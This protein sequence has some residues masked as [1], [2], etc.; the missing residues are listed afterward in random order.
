MQMGEENEL[1]RY[2]WILRRWLWLML[3]TTFLAAGAA[4]VF[5]LRTTPVY[6]ATAT[7]L[8]KQAPSTAAS[9]YTAILTSERL[10]RTYAQMIPSTVV[11]ENVVTRLGLTESAAE[12]AE[13]VR[14]EAVRDTLL[15]RL[16]VEDTEPLRAA[17]LANAIAEV[18][19][20]QNRELQEQRYAS[21]L[22]SLQSQ[23]DESASLIE[24]TRAQIEAL[25]E[26]QTAEDRTELARLETILAGYRNTY[27]ALLQSYEQTRLSAAQGSD[28]V[29]MFEPA[30][31]PTVPVRPRTAT[32][33]ALA[34][35]IGL[36]FG[37]GI[38]LLVEYLD[39]TFKSPDDVRRSLDMST[40][41]LIM[42][43]NGVENDL[44]VASDPSSP[45][46][47]AFRVLRT[48]L[49]FSNVD[50]P[51][52]KLL[53]T[54]PGPVE[55]KSVVTANLAAVI[56]QAGLRVVVDADLRR[57]RQHHIFGIRP[58]GGLSRA[59]LEGN[60]DSQVQSGR[61]AGLALLPAGG[62]PANP[63]EVLASQRMVRL[64]E[65]LADQVDVV[66]LDSPPVL[67][68]T[69]ATVLAR[70][71]DGVVL[72]LQA[73]RT[74]RVA[75]QQAVER[76]QQVGATLL[77]TVLNGI[78]PRG[79]GHYY[80]YESYYGKYYETKEARRKRHKQKRR[81]SLAASPAEDGGERG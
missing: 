70:L 53:V 27:S 42:R 30:E 49:W 46:A 51:P 54:S 3:L 45:V 61:L 77:G 1:L 59:L 8:V 43:F 44:I 10:I 74:R 63:A 67:P 52:R 62:L 4:L 33:T 5:S 18:F 68:V 73:G 36:M 37:S 28:D 81:A 25:G 21:S 56:A 13:R 47:E 79:G 29:V 26:P 66:L 58:Q 65:D 12:L 35:I 71:V 17:L 24:A 20:A 48:N 7:L 19:I 64:L 40:L 11:L 57:P 55:G 34:A 38:G 15:L 76:L 22:N 9:D 72:V 39:D 41:G 75:A 14:V 60:V 78:P 50:R 69:D 31:V 32:N 16:H 23:V 2:L 6:S 80:Y